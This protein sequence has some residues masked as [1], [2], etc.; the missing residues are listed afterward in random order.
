MSM[1]ATSKMSTERQKGI[2]LQ[3]RKWIL[4]WMYENYDSEDKLVT[5]IT[6]SDINYTLW[7]L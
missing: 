4:Y 5:R 2:K 1:T 3:Q 6:D 7:K